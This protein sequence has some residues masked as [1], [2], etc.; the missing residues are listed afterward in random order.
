LG[1]FKNFGCVRADKGVEPV[2]TYYG[3]G[4]SIFCDFVRTSFIDAISL[5][6]GT[7]GGGFNE[8]KI[9]SYTKD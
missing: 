9:A 3:K 4:E 5:L 6:L 1:F 8:I 7:I 2:R